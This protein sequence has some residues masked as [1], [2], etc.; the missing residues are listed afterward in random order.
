MAIIFIKNL[1]P[2][3]SK[4]KPKITGPTK[5]AELAIVYII[6]KPRDCCFAWTRLLTEPYVI[7]DE[8]CKN[9]PTSGRR[10]KE[11]FP[12]TK[13]TSMIPI[14]VST[15]KNTIDRITPNRAAIKP[16]AYF[17]KMPPLR[18][19]ATANATS[20]VETCFSIITKVINTRNPS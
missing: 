14:E 3:K 15:S 4:I 1:K 19:P 9:M 2:K 13:K 16:P 10:K 11:M 6:E 20:P 18:V 5:E 12:G 7:E 17:P 8:P